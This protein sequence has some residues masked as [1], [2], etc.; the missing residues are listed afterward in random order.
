MQGRAV[1]QQREVQI[2]NEQGL[3][4]RPIVQIVQLAT[5][6]ESELTVRFED[7]EA[8]GRSPLQMT[9]LLAPNGSKLTL[10]AEGSDAE[11]LLDAVAELIES[12]FSE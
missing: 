7:R 5:Q 4:L 3:H 10:E 8:D 2:C 6:F 11:A 12:G 9:M 1:V